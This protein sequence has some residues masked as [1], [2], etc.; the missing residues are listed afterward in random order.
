[1]NILATVEAT[2]TTGTDTIC[3]QCLD[4]LFLQR[5]V[6]VEVVEIERSEVHDGA[7]IGKLRLGAY[8]AEHSD[9]MH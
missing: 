9:I 8:G 2:R 7:S 5:L 1:M 4:C 6:G 3:A